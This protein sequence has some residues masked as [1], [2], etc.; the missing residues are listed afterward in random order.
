MKS[1][2]L[3]ALLSA[4]AIIAGT[5][6]FSQV[7][8]ILDKYYKVKDA[9]VAGNPAAASTNAAELVMEI[10]STDLKTI[11]AASQKEVQSIFKQLL[12]DAG[13]ISESKD[14]AK[15]REVFSTLSNNM[16]VLANKVKLNTSPVYVDYC[17]MKKCYWLSAVQSIRNPYYGNAM[18]SCGKI[19]DTLQ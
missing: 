1:I 16:I 14:V 5:S 3:P 19:S 12:N 13:L 8:G 18:L 17:P 11:A 10:N 6:V 2:F 4:F 15:Q 9:L 7:G